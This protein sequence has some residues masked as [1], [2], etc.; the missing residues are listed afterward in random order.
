MKRR[1]Q[2]AFL[3]LEIVVGGLRHP[4]RDRVAMERSPGQRLHHEQVERPL[5]QVEVVARHIV[6]LKG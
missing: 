2:R 3:D 5:H 6:P 1:V 4:A